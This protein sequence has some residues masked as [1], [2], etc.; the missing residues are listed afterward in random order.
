MGEGGGGAATV[1][2]VAREAAIADRFASALSAQ[3]AVRTAH[4][5]GQTLSKLDG[6]VD[7]VLFDRELSDISDDQLL[8]AIETD[9]LDCRVALL[10]DGDPEFDPIDRGFDGAVAKPV[11]PG[12]L[13]ETVE[14]L[15]ALDE[16]ERLYQELSSKRVERSIIE[17]ETDAE[18]RPSHD[19]LARL[20]RRIETLESRLDDI[21]HRA[22]FDDRLLPT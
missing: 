15:L 5:G 6:A 12:R 17:A 7:V 10:T 2:A 19:R 21:R 16:Y 22:E 8:D 14:R 4:N 3:Y 18:D 1:L 11:G 9:G 13:R 20:D